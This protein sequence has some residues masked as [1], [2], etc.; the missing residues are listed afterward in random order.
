MSSSYY[1]Y[2]VSH[3]P[4]SWITELGHPETISRPDDLNETHPHCDFVIVQVSGAP[5]KFGCPGYGNCPCGG[6]SNIEWINIDW[7][8]LLD[9]FEPDDCRSEVQE[10]L[11]RSTFSCWSFE[12]LK[13]L[14][15][16]M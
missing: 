7:L 16:Q 1:L 11:K 4:A 12:R 14:R 8:R 13:N 2:C 9:F 6:H 3:N 15:I 5:I 10:L